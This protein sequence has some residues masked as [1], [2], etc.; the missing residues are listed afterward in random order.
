MNSTGTNHHFSKGGKSQKKKLTRK[1]RR[2]R[3]EKVGKPGSKTST[4]KRFFFF[5]KKIKSGGGGEASQKKKP[6]KLETL[7][8]KRG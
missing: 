3:L 7:L 6:F 5:Y 8:E 4:S 1:I 2:H